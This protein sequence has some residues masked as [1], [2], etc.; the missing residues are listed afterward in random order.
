MSPIRGRV[1]WIGVLQI[2]NLLLCIATRQKILNQRKTIAFSARNRI[3][4]HKGQ[5]PT[6]FIRK[7]FFHDLYDPIN[8]FENIFCKNLFELRQDAIIVR[9]NAWRQP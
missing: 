4:R 9:V 3:D 1:G 6:G 8:I 7:E 2:N 5:V